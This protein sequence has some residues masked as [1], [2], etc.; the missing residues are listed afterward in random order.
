MR[1]YLVPDRVAIKEQKVVSIGGDVD[2]RNP[3]VLLVRVYISAATT[4]NSMDILLKNENTTTI[5]SNTVISRYIESNQRSG[6]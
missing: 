2:K 3:Y 1:Y 6:C 5:Y 4:P